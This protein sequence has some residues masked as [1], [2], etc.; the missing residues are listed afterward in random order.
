MCIKSLIT[1]LKQDRP[2]VRL[3]VTEVRGSTPRD[4]GATMFVSST[5]SNGTI[6][7][8]QLEYLAVK[9]ARQNLVS[10]EKD[11]TLDIFLGPEIGQCCGG[12]V[13]ITFK[14]LDQAA[15]KIVVAQV[16]A[17]EQALPKVYIFGAGHVGRAL[18]D[19]FQHLPVHCIL[20]DSRIEELNLSRA[21]VERRVSTLPEAEVRSAPAGSAFIVLTH[22]HALDFLVT[23][24]ALARTDAVWVGMIGSATKK[25]K[26]TSFARAEWPALATDDLNCPIGATRSRD[27]RPSV[28][29]AAVVSAVITAITCD[30]TIR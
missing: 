30:T 4:T 29:A 15:R 7:G 25:A 20:V 27:K 21:R 13:E 23:G 5:E 26:F 3:E 22:D 10:K 18:A 24:E 28:I 16:L 14:T 9:K 11:G 19:Q 2:I 6:G 17:D 1:F 8:G 12:R